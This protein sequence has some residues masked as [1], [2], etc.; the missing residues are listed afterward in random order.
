VQVANLAWIV[1][2]IAAAGWVAEALKIVAVAAA[3]QARLA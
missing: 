3:Y 1:S 2:V